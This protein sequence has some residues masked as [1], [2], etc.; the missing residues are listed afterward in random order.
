[1]DRSFLSR[2]EVIAASRSFVCIRLLT[3]EDAAEARFLQ[4]LGH[5][6]SGQVE[7]TIVCL[8][9][10]DCKQRL[11]WTARSFRE[12]YRDAADMAFDMKKVAAKYTGTS[13]SSSLPEV[14]GVRLGI[15]VAASDSQPLVVIN[16]RNAES[17]SR[18][19]QQLQ[20]LAWSERFIGRFVFAEAQSDKD[21]TAI[22]GAA[23]G[24]AILI[25]QPDKFGQ[26]GTILARSTGSSSA[27]IETALRT[28]LAAHQVF[29][30][31]FQNHVMA[32]HQQGIYWETAVP[33]TDPMERQARE[34]GRRGQP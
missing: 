14:A 20:Q 33:V 24:D 5:T 19:R 21:L 6:G 17:R 2:P 22:R 15:N 10:P 1:M 23:D 13:V 3:Y 16:S 12:I 25:V 4:S 26:K 7:N 30:K 11:S 8:I 28:G 18:I 31:S 9:S 27:D 29:D 34:R 32:G